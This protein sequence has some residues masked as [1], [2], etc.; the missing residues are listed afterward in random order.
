VL[1]KQKNRL[2]AVSPKS[3]QVFAV[4]RDALAMMAVIALADDDIDWT[5]A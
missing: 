4:S 3:D 2:A 1:P 5:L